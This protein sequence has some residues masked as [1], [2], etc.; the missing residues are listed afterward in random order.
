MMNLKVEKRKIK[1]SNNIGY[2]NDFKIEITNDN[3]ILLN[4][5][6]IKGPSIKT[7]EEAKLFIENYLS[8]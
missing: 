1:W 5:F 8:K 4:N 6:V 2:Y 7:K 3:K